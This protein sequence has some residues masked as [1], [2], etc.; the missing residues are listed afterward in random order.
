MFPVAE[1]ISFAAG[2]EILG[3]F[4]LFKDVGAVIVPQTWVGAV[5]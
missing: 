4:G 1:L 3:Q 5:L 2:F